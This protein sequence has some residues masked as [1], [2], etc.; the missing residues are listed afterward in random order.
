VKGTPQPG[1]YRWKAFQVDASGNKR[2][3]FFTRTIGNV[4][5][6]T[7]T[8]NP[9]S[10]AGAPPFTTTF[11]YDQTSNLADGT[12]QVVT[13]EVK[14]NAISESAD[15]EV[16][17]SPVQAGEPD[18]GLSLVKVVEFDAAGK[19]TRVFSPTPAVLLLPLDVISNQT[20]QAVGVDP[21]GAS[22][23]NEGTVKTRRTVDACG[24]LVDGW[25]VQT[26]ETYTDAAGN[27]TASAY[28][29]CV[30]TQL[31]G[32]LTFEQTSPPS[33]GTAAAGPVSGITTDLTLGQLHPGPLPVG[34]G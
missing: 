28:D 20:F 29:Y 7:K 9:Q 26:T 30:A 17:K 24:E 5:A 19:Q 27:S 2:F 4:S 3:G 33:S 8:A 12:K 34:S 32:I 1:S 15:A 16:T 31:G 23:V 21:T 25:E 11:T 6:I 13:Y 14:S 10:A 22:L 18:R